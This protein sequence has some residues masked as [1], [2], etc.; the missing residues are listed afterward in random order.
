MWTLAVHFFLHIILHILHIFFLH[1][2]TYWITYFAYCA[3]CNMQNMQNMDSALFYAFQV[4]LHVLHI[5]SIL[6]ILH[7]V[8]QEQ[9]PC[10]SPSLAA[11]Q[12]GRMD[13][14]EPSRG[15][16]FSW[17][18]RCESWPRLSL[19]VDSSWVES[20][21]AGA[22]GGWYIDNLWLCRVGVWAVPGR[23]ACQM[24]PV[25]DVK[26]ALSWHEPTGLHSNMYH[27]IH[28]H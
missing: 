28:T 14:R 9:P 7:I 20:Y 1:I 18:G 2:F 6:H 26:A 25:Q 15:P 4:I 3:Y 8:V 16:G 17:Q 24:L 27:C 11:H 10:L 23:Y 22:C 21:S 13:W 19:R 5:V 12:V